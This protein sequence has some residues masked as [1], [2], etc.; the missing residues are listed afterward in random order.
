VG[1]QVGLALVGVPPDVPIDVKLGALGGR[2]GLGRLKRC[3]AGRDG[4]S[5]SD[6]AKIAGTAQRELELSF[7]DGTL[8]GPAARQLL[9]LPPADRGD[10]ATAPTSDIRAVGAPFSA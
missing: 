3:T 9:E 5:G 2:E 1:E 7:G 6:Q 4:A 10:V 8:L